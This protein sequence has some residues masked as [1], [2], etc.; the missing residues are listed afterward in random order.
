[1]HVT[2]KSG[3]KELASMAGNRAKSVLSVEDQIREA[4]LRIGQIRR[5]IADQR[6]LLGELSA[7]GDDTSQATLLLEA[8]ESDLASAEAGRRWLEGH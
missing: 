6:I 1:M 2:L 5:R 7:R 4:S 3:K 8:L